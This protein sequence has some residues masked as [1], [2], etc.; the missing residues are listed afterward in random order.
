MSDLKGLLP[1]LPEPKITSSRAQPDDRRLARFDAVIVLHG[2]RGK[3]DAL[4]VPGADALAAVA[5]R[6][7]SGDIVGAALPGAPATQLV[8]CRIASD[9]TAFDRDTACRKAVKA[10]AAAN[11]RRVAVVVAPG[12]LSEH[13]PAVASAVTALAL[14]DFRMP[15]FGQA[16]KRRAALASTVLLPR[17]FARA[18]AFLASSIWAQRT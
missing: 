15:K 12:A 16:Q 17:P 2:R 18:L 13:G 3:L 5:A 1:K 4:D 9:A 14:A 8:A 6:G 11:A 7:E 10:I